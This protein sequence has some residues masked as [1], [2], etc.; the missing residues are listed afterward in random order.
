[1]ARKNS[2]F[3]GIVAAAIVALVIIAYFMD[4]NDWLHGVA[5]LWRYLTH[6]ATG[7]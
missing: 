3:G 5:L 2:G 4:P 6:A 7:K 1:M